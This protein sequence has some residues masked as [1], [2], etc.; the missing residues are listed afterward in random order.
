MIGKMD[1]LLIT[2]PYYPSNG[3]GVH[4]SVATAKYLPYFGWNP[5]VITRRY[6][7]TN[8][9]GTYD[10]QLAAEDDVCEVIRVDMPHPLL[11]KLEYR[12][13]S[14]IGSSEYDYRLN[15]LLYLRMK[16]AAE[17]VIRSRR[18]NALWSTFKPGIDHRIANYLSRKYAI[19]WI[20]DFRDLPDQSDDSPRFRTA[21]QQEVAICSSAQA[22]VATTEEL[23]EK[24]RAR[25]SIPIHAIYN[26]YDPE[27]YL[28]SEDNRGA[29]QAFTINYFGI[30]YEY[31]NPSKLF[32]ALDI[33]AY[34]RSIDLKKVSVNFYGAGSEMVKRFSDGYLSSPRVFAMDR[35]P[36]RDMIV[37][38]MQS[39]ILLIV[40]PPEQG[41]AIP[42]KLY[43]YL[44]SK[45][46]ILN[47]PGD[48]AGTDRILRDTNAGVSLSQPEE[49]AGWLALRYQEWK[50]SGRVQFTG[51]TSEIERYSRKTQI[52]DLAR[53]LSEVSVRRF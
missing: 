7:R 22:L 50:A 20:A 15:T 49:I 35:I 34:N 12:V 9:S 16:N 36:Y 30:L 5:T 39:Q 33:L 27:E 44:A 11:Q 48:G 8:S 2:V 42:A 14:A 52:G 29:D 40:A 24:L 18:I 37:R 28:C 13:L 26:G 10:E 1:V 45:R 25:H 41:G 21:V 19:P 4:R 32:V 17:R 38:Q 3:S 46:P 51:F 43:S 6:T 53:L 23:A 47:I 31:R